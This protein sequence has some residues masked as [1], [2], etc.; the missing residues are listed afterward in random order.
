MN[1][2]NIMS[3][4]KHMEPQKRVISKIIWWNGN[5][6]PVCPRPGYFTL[7]LSVIL[8]FWLTGQSLPCI[9]DCSCVHWKWAELV[10]GYLYFGALRIRENVYIIGQ[11]C[12]RLYVLV[13]L[14]SFLSSHLKLIVQLTIDTVSPSCVFY[15]QT[16]HP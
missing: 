6:S 4:K 2:L 9:S 12:S 3:S 14:L 16:F 1:K 5:M 7:L 10:K 11:Q 13:W 15:G 8:N